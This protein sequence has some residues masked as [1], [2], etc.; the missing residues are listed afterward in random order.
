M[1]EDI[2]VPQNI[3]GT[4]VHS[5]QDKTT[6]SNTNPVV[7]DFVDIPEE[8]L[9]LHQNVLLTADMFF[10]NKLTFVVTLSRKLCFGTIQYVRLRKKISLVKVIK[11][12][13]CLHPNRGL[14]VQSILMD[15]EF[16]C[17]KGALET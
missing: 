9:S 1:N 5:L 3:F 10:I 13:L 17:L 8:I 15:R 16:E 7:Q 6:R 2:V 11:K 4:D 14:N 12:V